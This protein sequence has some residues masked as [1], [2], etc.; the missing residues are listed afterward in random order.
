MEP[1]LAAAPHADADPYSIVDTS[2]FSKTK[3]VSSGATADPL[4]I[5]IRSSEGSSKPPLPKSSPP[6]T[7]N[8]KGNE[9]YDEALDHILLVQY[10][11]EEYI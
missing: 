3:Q 1:V 2:A 6:G 7:S 4:A 9:C 8:K 11:E 5:S 10:I